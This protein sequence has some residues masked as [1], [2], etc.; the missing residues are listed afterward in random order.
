MNDTVLQLCGVSVAWDG[1]QVLS[2]V[3]L[4]VNRGDLI[5]I[6]GP[7]GGGKTTLMRVVLGLVRPDSGT[8]GHPSG[9]LTVGYLPQKNQIDSH[10][11]VTVDEVIAQG[12]LSTR[13]LSRSDIRDRL[14]AMLDLVELRAHRDKAI[15][16]V[17]GGQLQRALLGRAL[18]ARP[19][20]L[21]LDEP[22]SY[23]D[24]HF[25]QRV[26]DIVGDLC[27]KTTILLVSHE[28]T[29]I[30]AM[31]NRHLVVNTTVS[32]CHAHHHAVHYDCDQC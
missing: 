18:I 28:M 26:Y 22:L 31:A 4:G 19:E 21:V 2:D 27:G 1:R 23:L 13:G 5:A 11:P 20:M 24:K 12:L 10:F 8:V 25:E 14:D 3:S 16:T 17:S 7:N 9:H 6:T 15:G 32:E 30:A 29:T